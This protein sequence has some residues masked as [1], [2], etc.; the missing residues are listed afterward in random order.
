[1]S[2]PVERQSNIIGRRRFLQL[3]GVAAGIATTAAYVNVVRRV[4]SS[5]QTSSEETKPEQQEHPQETFDAALIHVYGNQ[6]DGQIKLR[7]LLTIEAAAVLYKKGEVARF[8]ISG[9]GGISEGTMAEAARAA[10]LQTVAINPADIYIKT[11]LPATTSNE[12]SFFDRVAETHGWKR[13][14]DVSWSTHGPSI[15]VLGPRHL[16]KSGRTVQYTTAEAVLTHLS[17]V[18]KNAYYKQIFDELRQSTDEVVWN[19]YE[20][21]KLPLYSSPEGEKFL[22]TIST[23][24]RPEIN[25]R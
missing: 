9:P 16:E 24:W 6:P 17:G 5:C 25:R 1:M 7:T 3:A 12:F 8:V 14:L 15:C 21:I 23:L 22:N 19:I 13:L 10:L 2:A 18:E 4:G 20:G 11:D